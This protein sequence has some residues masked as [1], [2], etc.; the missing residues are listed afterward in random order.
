MLIDYS[1]IS[2]KHGK[3]LI[4]KGQMKHFTQKGISQT[5]RSKTFLE[6]NILPLYFFEIDLEQRNRVCLTNRRN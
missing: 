2:C 3:A 4:I 6:L 1:K 5:N